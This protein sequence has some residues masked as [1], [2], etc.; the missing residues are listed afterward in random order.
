MT[1]HRAKLAIVGSHTATRDQAPF[2]DEEWDIWIFNEAASL[3]R[4]PRFDA[5]FQLHDPLIWRDPSNKNDKNHYK[6]LQEPHDCTIW[7]QDQYP[8]V[9]SSKKYPLD[10]VLKIF[11]HITKGGDPIRFL[12][13]SPGYA[14][15][16]GIYMG[17]QE[18]ALYG[19][20]MN[21]N[22]EY[23]F[24][25]E[26]I[27]LLVGLAAGRGVRVRIPKKSELYS[28]PLYGYGGG[29]VIGR[30][31]FELTYNKIAKA[32]AVA[33]QAVNEASGAVKMLMELLNE[34]TDQERS[35]KLS[36]RYF[37]ALNAQQL[38][39]FNHGRLAGMAEA[40]MHYM[41]RVDAMIKAAGGEKA[42]ESILRQLEL[43]KQ[44]EPVNG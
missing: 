29:V 13:S 16:L 40:N 12:T 20:E 33:A 15:A 2:K 3:N 11:R 31:E 18:I 4:V 35:E 27:A 10:N 8:D 23:V 36:E 38:A 32:E 19:V 28:E 44:L 24:Q 14:L 43:D 39:I 21:T 30:Q 26:G 41:E 25:R 6:W 42:E 1:K 17:Y 9:P 37:A 34:E 5:V 22:T 7:M